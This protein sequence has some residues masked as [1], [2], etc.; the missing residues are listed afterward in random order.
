MAHGE[1]KPVALSPGRPPTTRA[2]TL[3]T[4]VGVAPARAKRQQFE[5]QWKPRPIVGDFYDNPRPTHLRRRL[6]PM[7]PDHA[8]IIQHTINNAAATH[9]SY[10]R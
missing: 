10:P 1:P 4:T 5:A 9:Q 2:T 7:H 6:R 8:R 3:A